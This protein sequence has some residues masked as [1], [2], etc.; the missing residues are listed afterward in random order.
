MLHEGETLSN[1]DPDNLPGTEAIFLSFQIAMDALEIFPDNSFPVGTSQIVFVHLL[2]QLF[3]AVMKP[4]E[5]LIKEGVVPRSSALLCVEEVADLLEY[6]MVVT[7]ALSHLDWGVI[8]SFPGKFEI[9][10]FL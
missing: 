1:F 2:P 4:R 9:S 7:G 3:Q 5:Q 6:Q 8:V 10:S